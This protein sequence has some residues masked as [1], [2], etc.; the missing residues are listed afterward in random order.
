[1]RLPCF[2]KEGVL[3]EVAPWWAKLSL[4]LGLDKQVVCKADS[5]RQELKRQRGTLRMAS[6]CVR[7]NDL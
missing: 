2:G 3:T 5:R 4:A 7:E 1:M 6:I